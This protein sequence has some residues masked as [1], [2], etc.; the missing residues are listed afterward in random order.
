MFKC[1]E[2]IAQLKLIFADSDGPALSM[3]REVLPQLTHANQVYGCVSEAPFA[4]V[5]HA[6]YSLF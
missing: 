2:L 5:W 3:E 1:S 4:Q 6:I